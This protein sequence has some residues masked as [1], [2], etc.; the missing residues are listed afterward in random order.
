MR[1]IIMPRPNY[2]QYRFF[3]VKYL[4][5]YLITCPYNVEAIVWEIFVN[6]LANWITIFYLAIV[7]MP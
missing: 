3:I 7:V 5:T 2:C 4:I 1:A 6:F